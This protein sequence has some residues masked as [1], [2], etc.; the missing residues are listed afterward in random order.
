MTREKCLFPS[1]SL[2][3]PIAIKGFLP[4][5]HHVSC[6]QQ[7]TFSCLCLPVIHV[8]QLVPCTPRRI[9]HTRTLRCLPHISTREDSP[10]AVPAACRSGVLR[11]AGVQHRGSRS[12]PAG[13]CFHFNRGEMEPM[14]RELVLQ[15]TATRAR[16]TEQD[17]SVNHLL[18]SMTTPPQGSFM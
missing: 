16:D 9:S 11:P 2:F 6:T 8:Q 3:I 1:T 5:S 13:R 12:A 7:K 14:G 10:T 15:L 4:I 18:L 17:S